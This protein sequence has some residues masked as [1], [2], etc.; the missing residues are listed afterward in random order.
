MDASF[1]AKHFHW[2]F[3]VPMK[4]PEII[5]A[6]C[7]IPPRTSIAHPKNQFGRAWCSSGCKTT[8]RM[9]LYCRRC[10]DSPGCCLGWNI[11]II[12][13]GWGSQFANLRSEETEEGASMGLIGAWRASKPANLK[14]ISSSHIEMSSAC[15]MKLNTNLR[16][17]TSFFKYV[18]YRS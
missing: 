15:L 17:R 1:S 10:R 11:L 5:N 16:N 13:T 9:W 6:V 2:I 12:R 14:L 18:D 8:G 3:H 4:Y 7:L